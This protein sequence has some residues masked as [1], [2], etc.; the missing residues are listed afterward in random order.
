MLSVACGRLLQG[1]RAR[2]WVD[3]YR[4][5]LADRNLLWLRVHVRLYGHT[6]VS[7][8]LGVGGPYAC[9]YKLPRKGG[10][11]VGTNCTEKAFLQREIRETGEPGGT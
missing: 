8:G 6:E 2:G 9:S 11:P 3:A 10:L 1:S 5:K 4:E 7:T